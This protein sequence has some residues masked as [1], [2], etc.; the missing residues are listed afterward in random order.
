MECVD[1]N[2]ANENE[3]EEILTEINQCRE[4]ER[5]AQNQMVQVIATAG[6]ILTLIFGANYITGNGEGIP[7]SLLFHLSNFVF[8]TA[9]GYITT[10]GINNVLRYHYL[11]DLEDKLFLLALRSS[12]KDGKQQLMHWMSLSAPITTKNPRHIKGPYTWMNYLCYTVATVSAIVFCAVITIVQYLSLDE[13]STYDQFSIG[14]LAVFFL[15]SLM[16]FFYSSYKAKDIYSFA[17]RASLKAR[18]TRT[19]T[20]QKQEAGSSKNSRPQED[21]ERQEER[22]EDKTSQK[23]RKNLFKTVCYFIYPKKKDLQKPILLA[24]GFITGIFLYQDTRP[25]GTALKQ[26]AI[27]FITMDFLL[28]QARYQWN[29]IRGLKQDQE[30][31]RRR[32]PKIG[33]KNDWQSVAV[34]MAIMAVRIAALVAVI[35]CF[36][37]EMTV[38]L[39]VCAV[40]IISAAILYEIA[41]TKDMSGLIFFSV[42]LGYP[43]RFFAGLWAAHP[44]IIDLEIVPIMV[45]KTAVALQQFW[46]SGQKGMDII[47]P[48]VILLLLAYAF[49]GINSVILAWTHEAVAENRLQKSHHKCLRKRLQ[50]GALSSPENGKLKLPWNWTYI[51]S[52]TFLSLNI[53][54]CTWREQPDK[55]LWGC[56]AVLELLTLSLSANIATPVLLFKKRNK[57]CLAVFFFAAILKSTTYILCADRYLFY[58]YIGLTQSLFTTTYFFLRYY[59]DPNF[60]FVEVI[61]KVVVGCFRLI[62]GKETFD[63]I[64]GKVMLIRLKPTP[65]R[66]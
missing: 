18:E 14:L 66:R 51:V 45:S 23:S 46:N 6:T 38:P 62:I 34:S 28:Y 4:D 31:G 55:R 30:A 5:S 12:E 10:V 8:C 41:R 40:L 43:L 29:D 20:Q 52:M 39:L 21:S 44:Q 16:V 3:R 19:E 60:D 24:L 37:G 53:L 54:I 56:F 36:G 7:Q 58:L 49:W 57:L 61:K 26:F 11:R 22:E 33:E 32:L 35:L 1:K 50:K 63:Y 65:I 15:L 42:S 48:V 13:Y 27:V 64:T 25:F 2:H 59:F 47:G 9:I 17:Q